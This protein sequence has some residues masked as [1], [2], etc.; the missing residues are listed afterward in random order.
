MTGPRSRL[1]IC[2][3]AALCL[4]AVPARADVCVWR[5][6]VRTMTKLFPEASDYRTVTRKVTPEAV[7]TIEERVGKPL[8]PGEK[9]EFN[10]YEITGRGGERLGTVLALAGKGDYGVIEVVVGLDTD[11]KIAGVYVQKMRERQ[12]DKLRHDAFLGQ[13]RGK[14]KEDGLVLG[15]DIEPVA[16]APTASREVALA[17]KKMLIFYDVLEERQR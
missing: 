9:V 1:F 10:Y 6:P 17:I 14:S 3:P 13:F 4:V 5:D 2:L 15:T 8:D 12:A 11:E 7:A 16:E